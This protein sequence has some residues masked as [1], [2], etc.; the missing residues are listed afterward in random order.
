[1]KYNR[2]LVTCEGTAA[3]Y[4]DPTTE[5]RY[6]VVWAYSARDALFQIRLIFRDK[7]KQ[8]SPPSETFRAFRVH[9]FPLD[10]CPG[11]ENGKP[12]ARWHCSIHGPQEGL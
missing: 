3:Y 9:A 12:G 5:T 10:A 7:E 1:M 2:Y 8:S 11:C 4:R 6:R